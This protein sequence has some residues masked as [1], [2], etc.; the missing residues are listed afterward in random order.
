MLPLSQFERLFPGAQQHL[1]IAEWELRLLVL[2]VSSQNSKHLMDVD[3]SILVLGYACD[4]ALLAGHRE[5]VLVLLLVGYWNKM[6]S[7]VL[8]L[9]L[10]ILHRKQREEDYCEWTCSPGWPKKKTKEQPQ[11]P[12]LPIQLREHWGRG[13]RV[14]IVASKGWGGM[15][16]NSLLGT[17]LI[18]SQIAVVVCPKYQHP[19]M[20][21]GAHNG[22]CLH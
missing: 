22:L 14:K 20:E 7:W 13:E 6:L 5:Q 12:F 11:N 21:T 17:V 4:T 18:K 15:L 9:I 2:S 16:P 10:V 1:H 19:I 8:W 3:H